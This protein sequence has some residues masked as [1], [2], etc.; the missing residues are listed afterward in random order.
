MS[1][2]FLSAPDITGRERELITEVFDS[3]Y[4]APIGEMLNRFEAD[5]CKYTG[6]SHA[7]A[8]SSGTAALHL[9]LRIAGVGKGDEVWTTSMTFIG[10]ASPIVFLGATPVFFDLSSK[11]WTIDPDLLESELKKAD[12]KGKLPKVILPTDLYGQ[13]CELDH[14]IKICDQYGVLLIVDSAEA[15]GAFYHGKHAGSGG[16]SAIFSFNGN[17]MMTTSGGGMLVSN[18][19]A[20]IDQASYLST[21]ARQPVIHYEHV[22]IGYNYRLSN[23]CAAI[24]VGQLEQ[25]ESKVEKR[26]AH[27]DRYVKAFADNPGVEFMPEPEGYRSTRWL[28]CLTLSDDMKAS[29]HDVQAACNTAEI[30][31]RPLWKPM[32]MQPVFKDA[33]M[34]GGSVSED[35]FS[36]GLCLPSGSGMPLSDQQRVIDV[37][38]SV[39]DE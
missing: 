6:F 33:K 10:G 34:I 1:R 36:R 25:I 15:V 5:M 31:V 21:Q 35:L 9:A 14:L 30:E 16:H 20:V 17:K 32:H 11:H 38:K 19:K 23:V 13:S 8:L 28:T 29:R 39:I 12:K 27:F 24:G 22:D 7:V 18:D 2:I 3:N 4:I 37:I 26:R